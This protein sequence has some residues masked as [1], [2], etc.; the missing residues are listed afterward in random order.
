MGAQVLPG[1][2]LARRFSILGSVRSVGDGTEDHNL[3][4]MCV[5][6][7]KLIF[8]II[9]MKLPN[10]VSYMIFEMWNVLN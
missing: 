1:N 7:Y 6:A 5:Y 4:T 8:L 9:R 10:K 2:F 3:G